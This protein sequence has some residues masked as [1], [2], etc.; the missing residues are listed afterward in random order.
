MQRAW[1]GSIKK[2]DPHF[3]PGDE[4]GETI[5]C[6]GYEPLPSPPSVSEKS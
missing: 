3:Y 1:C 2:H 6:P 4:P 5:E